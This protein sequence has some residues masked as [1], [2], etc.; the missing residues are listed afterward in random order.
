MR[1]PNDPKM[2]LNTTRLKL[3]RT[4]MC[5]QYPRVPNFSPCLLYHQPFSSSGHFETSALNDHKMADNTTRSNAF[6]IWLISTLP[7][8]P[9]VHC[10]VLSLR[11]AVV[12]ITGN[13][14]TSV[15]NDTKMRNPTR[16]NVPPDMSH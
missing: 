10:F 5:Y 11:P 3:L 9:K 4:C 2:T 16:A 12:H 14:E 6:H 1:V 15:P 8:S 7:S 13:F